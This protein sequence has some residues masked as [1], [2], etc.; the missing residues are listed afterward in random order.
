MGHEIKKSIL[1]AIHLLAEAKRGY[2]SYYAVKT[3]T[4]ENTQSDWRRIPNWI[5][6]PMEGA[7]AEYDDSLEQ[8]IGSVLSSES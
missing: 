3:I 8:I 6:G 5:P 4:W 2:L 1:H 7:N